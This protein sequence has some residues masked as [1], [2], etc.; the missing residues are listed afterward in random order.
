MIRRWSAL[1][2]AVLV[3]VPALGAGVAESPITVQVTLDGVPTDA[4]VLVHRAGFLRGVLYT[5]VNEVG[6]ARFG[7]AWGDYVLSVSHGGGF[8]GEVVQVPIQVRPPAPLTVEV[9][10]SRRFDPAAWGYYG[11]D[12]HAHSAVSPD[13]RTP[14]EQLVA[15]QL[16]ADL[17]V[18][19]L[20]DH[21]SVSGHGAFA[22]TAAAR[23]VPALLSEEITAPEWGHFNPYPLPEGRLVPYER[24]RTPAR[25]RDEARA[26]GASVFQLNHP[27]SRRFGHLDKADKPGFDLSVF[28]AWEIANGPWD[29]ANAASLAALIALWNRGQRITAVGVSDDHDGEDLEV[30]YGMPRTYAH[31]EGPLSAAAWASGLKAGHAFVSYGPLVYLSAREA[32]PGDTLRLARGETVAFEV[33]LQSV[34]PLARVDVLENGQETSVELEDLPG[35]HEVSFRLPRT[36]TRSGWLAL[37]AWDQE[38]AFALTNPIWIEVP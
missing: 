3:L 34:A 8:T 37:R 32:R 24:G 14:V 28:D 23:G 12:T 6:T 17:D 33:T 21:N 13:G 26:L 9:P 27:A 38:G 36:F 15:V 16:A 18:V 20:S 11:G 30:Q 2:L 19:F 7:L 35:A 10:L 29:E 31:V 4:Q 22:R 1:V 25:Y 5:D